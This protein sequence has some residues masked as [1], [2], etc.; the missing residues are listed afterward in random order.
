MRSELQQ[1]L[2]QIDA[3]AEAAQ[4]MFY[5]FGCVASHASIVARQEEIGEK[6]L[7]AL[8]ALDE[9]AEKHY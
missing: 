3:E 2:E 5:Q 7:S 4:R 8:K 6:Y 1:L 9:E